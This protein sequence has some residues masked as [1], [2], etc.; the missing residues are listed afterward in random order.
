MI[1]IY[2]LI[3]IFILINAY[4][5]YENKLES[6]QNISPLLTNQEIILYINVIVVIYILSQ[7]YIYYTLNPKN[8]KKISNFTSKITKDDQV[9]DLSDNKNINDNSIKIIYWIVINNNQKYK[10]YNTNGIAI[11][12]NKKVNIS[13]K[14]IESYSNLELKYYIVNK[15]DS[16]ESISDINSLII[17]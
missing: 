4:I 10:N 1:N 15:T 9:F 13:L 8:I 12:N 14:N 11:I 6:I 16:G 7:Y 5:I 3:I 17:K 2:I